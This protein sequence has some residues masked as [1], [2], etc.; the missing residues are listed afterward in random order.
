MSTQDSSDSI[1]PRDRTS[2]K[3]ETGFDE[4]SRFVAQFSATFRLLVFHP[5]RVEQLVSAETRTNFV[6]PITFFVISYFV[7]VITFS[8][9]VD[10]FDSPLAETSVSSIF[11]HVSKQLPFLEA[12]PGKLLILSLPT[13]LFL[14]IISS[15]LARISHFDRSLTTGALAYFVACLWLL[16]AVVF[17]ISIVVFFLAIKFP[18]DSALLVINGAGVIGFILLFIPIF[19]LDHYFTKLLVKGHT[20][21]RDALI[22]NMCLLTGAVLTFLVFFVLG[23]EGSSHRKVSIEVLHIGFGASFS[24]PSTLLADITRHHY[25]IIPDSPPPDQQK[26][27]LPFQLTVLLRNQGSHPY[28]LTRRLKTPWPQLV[29]GIPNIPNSK[30]ASVPD[31][32]A[33]TQIAELE[34]AGWSD[35]SSPVLI[36]NAGEVK[37]VRFVGSLR[38]LTIEDVRTGRFRLSIPRESEGWI[39]SFWYSYCEC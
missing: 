21:W 3:L 18:K 20:G 7:L 14:S 1:P 10:F 9:V 26:P 8:V 29:F 37:W 39:Q 36:L 34:V 6:A 4:F 35:S 11:I 31:T 27:N 28:I 15:F 23:S 22:S 12:S 13:L 2:D 5:S 19:L 30:G 33:H 17:T 25:I 24:G 32:L 16:I 38:S